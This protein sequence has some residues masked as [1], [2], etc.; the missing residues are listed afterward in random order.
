MS[1]VIGEGTYGCVHKP[2]LK[3]KNHNVN[4]S[5]KVSK[6]EST[7][8]ALIEMKEYAIM[9]QL[10][11]NKKMHLGKPIKCTVDDTE[12]NKRSIQKCDNSDK[13]MNLKYQSLIIMKNGGPNLEAYANM[14]IRIQPTHISKSKMELFWIDG[15]RIFKGIKTFLKNGV[16][17]HDLKPQ[18][19]V[20]DESQHRLNFID[21][22]LMT[23]MR[24]ILSSS[25]RSDNWLSESH[26][27]FPFE[28]QFYNKH[29]FMELMELDKKTELQ[30]FISK[31][32]RGS[33]EKTHTM[34]NTFFSFCLDEK[35]S[36][37][38][39]ASRMDTYLNDYYT[40]MVQ[41]DKTK[42][43]DFLKRSANTIDI[44]GAGIAFVY[45]LNKSKQLISPK[46]AADLDALFYLM[47][48][49]NLNNR[50][51]IDELIRRY[52]H[53]LRKHT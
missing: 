1:D 36:T 11:K 24:R 34:I 10:D 17:H 48:T 37:Y 32:K 15:Q 35:L 39:Y 33:T 47:L 40:F 25:M 26:W 27:S 5:D 13:F 51:Q 21:F 16:I 52:D 4:Y 20:Y 8:E 28:M 30:T 44:Y 38:D 50:L 7:D 23:T 12:Y 22:G 46:F 45:V 49:P 6:I 43:A 9:S 3:C 42:Y 14:L 19:I 29:R 2:S 41:L 18:N 53:I 31:V